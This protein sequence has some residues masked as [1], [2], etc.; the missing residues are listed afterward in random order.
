M[1]KV[2]TNSVLII[3]LVVVGGI[4][5]ALALSH[6]PQ[7]NKEVAMSDVFSQ[8]PASQTAVGEAQKAADPVPS[9]AI[10]TNPE[11]GREAGFMVQVYSFQ[12]R[13]RAEKALDN[14]KI[15]GY[16]AF[17][18]VSDLGEKGTWYRVRI[19]G[20]NDE[21]QAQAMLNQVRKNYQGGFIVKPQ[22]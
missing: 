15:S 4:V 3:G 18:E 16:N 11:N 17:M 2:N 8:A 1:A 19:G 21:A 13:V 5:A 22:L 7:A 14:L 9:P 12:D 10:V 6:K 20:L